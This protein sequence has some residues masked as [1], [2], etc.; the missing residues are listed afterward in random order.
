MPECATFLDW[1]R[2]ERA[3]ARQAWLAADVA[4]ERCEREARKFWR[5]WYRRRWM[6]LRQAAVIAMSRAAVRRDV[7]DKV[8]A[9]AKALGLAETD[10]AK[11]A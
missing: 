3:N 1:L 2:M 7:L 6:F 8:I 9:K 4:R 10:K 11:E 5:P